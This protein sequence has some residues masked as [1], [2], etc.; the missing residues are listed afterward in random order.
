VPPGA[1]RREIGKALRGRRVVVQRILPMSAGLRIK[2]LPDTEKPRERLMAQGAE[3]LSD[4]E[5]IA[6]L[7]RV[8]MRGRSAV[9]VARLM[10]HQF[11]TLE[12]LARASVDELRQVKGI[13]RDKA[14]ALKAAFTLAQRMARE[15]RRDSAPLDTPDQIADMLREDSRLRDVECFHTVLL[16]TRHRLIRIERISTGTLDTILVHP[17]EVFKSAIAANAAALVLVHNH[18]SGDP[19]P[20]EADIKVTR[21][22]I[23]AGQVLKI[24]VLDHIILG[25]QT[26][27]RAKDYVSLRELGYFHT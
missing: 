16:N 4:A 22:L 2:D 10:L 5:L 17:R 24:D 3:A 19:S 23:R 11:G 8:G 1:T 21:D 6:I 14:I 13:G 7:I 18:P 25:R 20:S 26:A 15:M 12:R 9:D 27:E